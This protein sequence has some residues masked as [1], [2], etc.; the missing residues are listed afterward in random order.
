[1]SLLRAVGTKSEV[2]MFK[3][4]TL[5]EE[6]ALILG[7]LGYAIWPPLLFSSEKAVNIC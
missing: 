6:Q 5:P 4:M 2:Q 3:D 7:L 1:M